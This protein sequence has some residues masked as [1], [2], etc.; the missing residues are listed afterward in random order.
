MMAAARIPSCCRNPSLTF[1]VRLPPA[2]APSMAD[3][4]PCSSWCSHPTCASSWWPS[5]SE[6][7][8]P[9][10]QLGVD[11]MHGK[12]WQPRPDELVFPSP[13]GTHT[14]LPPCADRS[15]LI[16]YYTSYHQ[17]QEM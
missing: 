4:Q 5:P 16:W 17:S 12:A 13:L 10:Q 7:H 2:L 8:P 6:H 1:S 14:P 3:M 9:C 15:L 11:D